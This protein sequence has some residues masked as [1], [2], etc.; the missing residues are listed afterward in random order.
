MFDSFIRRLLVINCTLSFNDN[1][2]RLE[3]L[4]DIDAT[5]YAFIDREIAQLVCN[6]LNMKSVSLLKSKSLIE[7]DDRHASSITHVIYFKLTIEL[8]FELI[9]FLLIIDLDSHS[10]ILEKSWMNKH[11]VILNMIY[12]KLIFKSFKCSHHDSILSQAMQ[13]RRLKTLRSNRRSNVSNWRRDAIL[14][15][16]DNAEHIATMNSRYIILSRLK[17]KSLSSTVENESNAF[18]SECFECSTHSEVDHDDESF[19]I[20]SDHSEIDITTITKATFVKKRN[21]KRQRN[22]RWKIRKQQSEFSSFSRLNSDDSMN[23][24]MIDAIFFCLL[25]DVKD[26]KQKV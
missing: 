16:K 24:A 10:I 17:I 6:M 22:K 13:I 12:D 20:E 8:H 11:E 25:I 5:D 15:Q 21:L 7:F 26:R 3:A 4:I 2:H 18:D 14:S 1:R 23:I 9:V 19:V